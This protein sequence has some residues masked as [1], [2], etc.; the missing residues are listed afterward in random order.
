M[1]RILMA[2]A[3]VLM[4]A[5]AGL[6]RVEAAEKKAGGGK[7]DLNTATMSELEELPGVGAAT[8][9]KIVAGRPYKAVEDLKSVGV[10]EATITKISPLVEV[11]AVKRAAAVGTRTEAGGKVDL[12]TATAAELEKLPGVGKA[13]A[14]KIIE[15]RPYKEVGELKG[16]SKK[17]I[18]LPHNL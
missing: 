14:K 10:S 15:G 9:R 4:L 13:T 7:V 16:T 1:R 8:A 17:S 18:L 2:G 3:V 5:M 6:A 12:N 11:K